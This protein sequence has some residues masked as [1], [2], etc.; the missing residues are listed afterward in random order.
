M[1]MPPLD[2]HDKERYIKILDGS[3][4]NLLARFQKD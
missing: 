1:G 4:E 2:D 3:T